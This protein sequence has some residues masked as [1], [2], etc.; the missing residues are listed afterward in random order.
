MLAAAALAGEV[1]LVLL[2]LDGFK[3]MNDTHGHHASRT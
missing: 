3:E 1:S 2:D